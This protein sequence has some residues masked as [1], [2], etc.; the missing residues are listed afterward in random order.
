M[1]RRRREEVLAVVLLAMM[2]FAPEI[3][4]EERMDERIRAV[5]AAR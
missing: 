5:E 3:I 2:V 1:I 4:G